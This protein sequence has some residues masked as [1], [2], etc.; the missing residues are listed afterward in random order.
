[1]EPVMIEL[2]DLQV[3]KYQVLALLQ[4]N[5]FYAHGMVIK[6]LSIW[7]QGSKKSD[8]DV[9]LMLISFIATPTTSLIQD[10]S[11][12]QS[13]Q[14]QDQGV[15]LPKCHQRL[16]LFYFILGDASLLLLHH[17]SH[18]LRE[19]DAAGPVLVG[20]IDHVLDLVLRRILAYI[21]AKP[22]SIVLVQALLKHIL[23]K[24]SLSWLAGVVQSLFN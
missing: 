5:V 3:E 16:N 14:P 7:V 23:V 4:A 17:E 11:S 21:D 2:H 18:E 8:A 19:V 9:S 12:L 22:G 10:L 6:K 24:S 13:I 20:V 15:V 1:M